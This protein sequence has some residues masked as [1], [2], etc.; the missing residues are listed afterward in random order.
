MPLPRNPKFCWFC[1][2]LYMFVMFSL[3][4]IC[5][6]PHKFLFAYHTFRFGFVLGF[7]SFNAIHS[8][9]HAWMSKVLSFCAYGW[10]CTLHDGL[11]WLHEWPSLAMSTLYLV[12]WACAQGDCCRCIF[13][14]YYMHSHRSVIVQI[15][16]TK[17]HRFLVYSTC[18]NVPN[19][20]KGFGS[21]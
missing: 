9:V 10:S 1:F 4:F 8:H 3:F 7:L 21:S 19:A 15:H 17:W 18:I 12:I 20:L 14:S 13:V 5:F 6:R 2:Y 11:S 16:V